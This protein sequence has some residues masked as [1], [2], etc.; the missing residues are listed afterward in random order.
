MKKT[1]LRLNYPLSIG[2]FQNMLYISTP[3][4]GIYIN[5][6]FYK[7]INKNYIEFEIMRNNFKF[8]IEFGNVE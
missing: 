6:I 7:D 2:D 1:I 4:I 8:L 3:L 5:C